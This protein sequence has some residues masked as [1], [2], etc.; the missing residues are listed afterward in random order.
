M[1]KFD[2]MVQTR[3]HRIKVVDRSVTLQDS[4]AVWPL[5]GAIAHRIE[6][7]GSLIL[8]AN[9]SGEVVIRIGVTCARK[10]A[11]PRAEVAA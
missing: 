11:A 5:I 10:L 8:V 9:E 6:E 4:S 1:A 3:D 2:F 7:P